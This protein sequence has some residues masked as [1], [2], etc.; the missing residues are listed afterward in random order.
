MSTRITTPTP[1]PDDDGRHCGRDANGPDS[2]PTPLR[3][4]RESRSDTLP[5]PPTD[6]EVRYAK[7]RPE[8]K[9]MTPAQEVL[10][11]VATRSYQRLVAPVLDAI[12]RRRRAKDK[13]GQKPHW[14]MHDYVHLLI[15]ER[16]IGARGF[17][18][19]RIW[20]TSEAGAQTRQ[21]LG[22]TVV[23]LRRGGNRGLDSTV[24]GRTWFSKMRKLLPEAQLAAL[25]DELDRE[26]LREHAELNP[27]FLTS[28]EVLYLDGTV[29]RTHATPPKTKRDKK[30]D[31]VT[32]FNLVAIGRDGGL[33]CPITAPE[34]G[35]ISN[36]G[37]NEHYGSGWNIILAT[38]PQG[39]IIAH[40][41][42]PL[43]ASE[44]TEATALTDELA[45][46]LQ[47][48][49]APQRVRVLAADGGFYSPRLA[50]ALRA[51]GFIECI[52]RTSHYKGSE[53]TA[54]EL[55][56]KRY[57]LDGYPNWFSD[58]HRQLCCACGKATF[59]RRNGLD[60]LGH[61]F[62]RVRGNCPNCGTA[63]VTS[64]QWRLAGPSGAEYFVRCLPDERDEADMALGN[65]LPFD[66]LR[67]KEYGGPRF[68]VQEG[69]FGSELCQRFGLIKNK[70][71]FFRQ[72]QVDLEVAIVVCLTH[73]LSILRYQRQM[74]QG[75]ADDDATGHAA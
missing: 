26:L 24:P 57:R 64:G 31:E 67:A 71:R 23:P 21:Q 14:T 47:Y 34:A 30:T 32:V 59:V 18:D 25:L 27:E 42:P 3:G 13:R 17:A 66:D 72:S 39:D 58:G 65:S 74:Q 35:Y 40:R 45:A 53:E 22:F 4:A 69:L 49:G 5:D 50:R 10:A 7:C 29:L 60:H 8:L 33:Y 62:S 16:V 15:L 36:H 41:H 73:A 46:R 37:R 75:A 56:N 9:G 43:N 48:L 1:D 70:R 63:T 19:L 20:L 55:R 28:L 54:N 2:E 68:P 61:A 11:L 51:I 12:E 38:T 52:H 6:F 44:K